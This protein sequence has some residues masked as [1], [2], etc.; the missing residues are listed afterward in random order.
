MAKKKNFY[1]VRLRKDDSIVAVGDAEECTK[2]LGFSSIDVFRTMVSRSRM[3]LSQ[4][5]KYDVDVVPEE[6]DDEL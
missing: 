4:Y 1:I 6:E 2:A 5:S 3:H